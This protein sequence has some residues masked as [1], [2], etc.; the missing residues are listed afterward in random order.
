MRAVD[1]IIGIGA[2]GTFFDID[3][4]PFQGVATY[5]YGV[6]FSCDRARAERHSALGGSGRIRAE[7]RRIQSQRIGA[8][9]DGDRIVPG[10]LRGFTHGNRIV[11][12]GAGCSAGG[13]GLEIFGAT[14]HHIGQLVDVD[15][16]LSIGAGSDIG[17]LA[18]GACAAYRN[19]VDAVGNGV[20]TQGNAVLR[21]GIRLVAHGYGVGCRRLGLPTNRDGL[22]ARSVRQ[23]ATGN[24]I[25]AQGFRLVAD[26]NGI[27]LLGT[28]HVAGCNRAIGR[29][30]RLIAAGN[31]AV[32]RCACTG[33][34]RHRVIAGSR[35]TRVGRIGL[36]VLAAFL[37]QISE[38]I[39]HIGVEAAQCDAVPYP[40]GNFAT[41]RSFQL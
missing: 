30:V 13:V 22:A 15:R 16:I 19:G 18:F 33:A 23:G 34:D 21:G 11:T 29:G 3:E 14:F 37:V 35:R 7:C 10:R 41:Q 28:R 6:R 5:R 39:A 9:T 8:G 2:D 24:G 12:G 36:E 31:G 32:S 17:D 25:G 40:V 27:F 38:R 1:C 26:G 4:F 20:C